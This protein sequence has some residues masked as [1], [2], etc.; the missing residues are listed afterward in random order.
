MAFLIGGANTLDD[1]YE[2]SNSVRFEGAAAT[3]LA[4]FGNNSRDGNTFTISAWIK[5]VKLV[6]TELFFQPSFPFSFH[7]RHRVH[8]LHQR[9][10]SILLYSSFFIP[11]LFFLFLL[12]L[13]LYRDI[14]STPS[15]MKT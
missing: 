1:A 9:L 6:R 12:S 15:Q 4:R 10:Y 7:L 13:N 3:G 14:Y 11:P 2:I 5:R 8:H